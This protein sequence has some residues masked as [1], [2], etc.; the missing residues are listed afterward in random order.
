MN[1]VIY[2]F[3]AEGVCTNITVL[4]GLERL[5]ELFTRSGAASYLH[6][7]KQIDINK[8]RNIAGVLTEVEPVLTIEQQWAVIRD[9]RDRLL[10]G[11]DWTQL[12]DIP[13]DNQESWAIYRQQLRD[14]TT[15]A[16]PFNIVWPVPPGG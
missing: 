10:L 14:I 5:E 8:A 7:D 9:K 16:D 2:F 1:N 12:P 15:Q 6:S 11:T 3:N 4:N 13:Q